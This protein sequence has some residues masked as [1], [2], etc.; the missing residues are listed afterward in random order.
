VPVQSAANRKSGRAGSAV[1]CGDGGRMRRR[2]RQCKWKQWKRSRRRR[3]MLQQLGA[4]LTTVPLASRS[5]KVC[6]R[7]STTSLVQAASTHEWLGQQGVPDLTALWVI[8][9]YPPPPKPGP[10]A[11]VTAT[12]G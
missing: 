1:V 5:R 3:E 8:D 9:H 12:A 6:W 10:K 7:M 4:D 2:V 11:P